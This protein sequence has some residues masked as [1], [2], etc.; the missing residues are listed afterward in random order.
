[1]STSECFSTRSPIGYLCRPYGGR[2]FSARTLVKLS[3]KRRGKPSSPAPPA[4]VHALHAREWQLS[5][6]SSALHLR[7]LGVHNIGGAMGH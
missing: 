3:K 1:M 4:P 7:G 5:L 6:R 2:E